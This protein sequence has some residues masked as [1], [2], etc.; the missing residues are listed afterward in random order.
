MHSATAIQPDREFLARVLASGGG[1]LKRCFQCGTCSVVCTLSPDDAPFPRAQMLE[2][3]W[4]LGDRLMSDPAVWLCHN[5]G[6]CTDHCP[7]DA[8]PGDVLGAVRAEAI[9]HF[10]VPRWLAAAAMSPAGLPWLLLLP[11]LVF[12]A[13][14]LWAP[15]DPVAKGLEFA[16][17]FPQPA[18]E[19][20]FF[21]VAG[22]AVLGFA[23]GLARFVRALPPEGRRRILPNLPSAVGLIAG[24]SQ[25][26]TAR[27]AQW[28]GHL[29]TFWGFVG[30]AVVGTVVGVGT[31][32][33]VMHTPLA[34][35]SVF[36]LGANACALVVTAGL[37]WRLYDRVSD[38]VTRAHTTF[39]D[40]AFLVTIFSV[41]VTGIASEALRLL[42]AASAMYPVYFV[43]LVLVFA[44]F[45][46]APYTKFAHLVYRTVA[47]AAA[48]GRR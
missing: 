22:V 15:P 35:M 44:L 40:W 25:F 3:Q 7:R 18:L 34:T 23:A 30:L 21:T 19:A 29:L 24:H 32:A 28:W 26:C 14:A 17:V 43:H 5:C 27:P 45:L 37:A 42:G 6:D 1:D 2:A 47:V 48:G 8:R 20:L 38:P 36:K 16:R 13:I 41:A 9:R 4:G 46:Y 39:T 10:A 31:M 11:V 12:A 33:G